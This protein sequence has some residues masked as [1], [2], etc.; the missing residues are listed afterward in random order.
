M[1][2]Q[3]PEF[4]FVSPS[5]AVR[6]VRVSMVREASVVNPSAVTAEQAVEFFN[7]VV[8]KSEWFDEEKECFVVLLLNVKT[9][10]TGFNLVSLGSQTSASAHPRD[11]FRAAIVG[12]A[13]AIICL[14]NHPSGDPAPSSADISVT[15]QLREASRVLGIDLT[16]H[17]IVGNPANDPVNVGFYSFRQA[18]LV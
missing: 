7:N 6:E 3:A 15:R 10:I 18:G 12:A 2:S 14:H 13:N 5:Y 9:R 1:S 16:D 8:K 17:I 4:S 11:V